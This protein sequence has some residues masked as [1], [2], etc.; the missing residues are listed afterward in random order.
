MIIFFKNISFKT[1]IFPENSSRCSEFLQCKGCGAVAACVASIDPI[2]TEA[3][4]LIAA[5]LLPANEVLFDFIG[6]I[7]LKFERTSKSGTYK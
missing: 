5:R 1:I 6:G 4:D 7:I 2:F 3:Q